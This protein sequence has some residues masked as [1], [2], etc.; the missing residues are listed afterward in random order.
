MKIV[1]TSDTHFGDCTSQLAA[2]DS[3]GNPILGPKY[4]EFVEACGTNNDY[5]V[6]LGD[7]IDVAIFE[8]SISSAFKLRS[9]SGRPLIRCY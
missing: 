7:V 4:H 8:F 2:L 1:I 5:L 9:R 6:M 3:N